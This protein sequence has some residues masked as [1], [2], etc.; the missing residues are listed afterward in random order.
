MMKQKVKQENKRRPVRNEKKGRLNSLA[1]LAAYVIALAAA[2]MYSLFLDAAYGWYFVV[3][4]LVFPIVSVALTLASYKRVSCAVTLSTKLLYK[5]EKLTMT[6]TLRNSSPFPV[7]FIYITTCDAVSFAE[8]GE[9]RFGVMLPPRKDFSRDYTYTAEIW[10]VSRLGLK[11]IFIS[12]FFGILSLPLYSEIEL[13]GRTE[14]VEIFPNIPDLDSKSELIKAICDTAAYEDSDE[15][16]SG[17]YMP[18]GIPGYEHRAYQPGDPI[19]RINW[20]LSSKRD[21]LLLR[22]DEEIISTK[23]LLVLDPC[24][25]LP[26]I[27]KL[28][29]MTAAAK[30]DERAVEGLLAMLM[31][32]VK[33]GLQ[34]SLCLYVDGAWQFCTAETVDDVMQLQLYMA[35]YRFSS[36]SGDIAS[37]RIPADACH[38]SGDRP[39]S[40]VMFTSRPDMSL[41]SR[42]E[43]LRGSN[44]DVYAVACTE[45][46]I[47]KANIWQLNEGFELIK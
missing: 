39:S 2:V 17:S 24:S 16:G 35:H 1:A 32:L 40:L 29:E 3:A 34:C 45:T 5:R 10:G 33:L 27:R 36:A 25:Y 28:D 7:P 13:L 6:V 31:S 22:M 23:Q 42:L 4:M 46:R 11:S 30:M 47:L 41:L 8:R 20:K 21:L 19:K 37:K 15:S 43:E 14:E 18:S 38:S 44:V 26:D 9:K 12:D